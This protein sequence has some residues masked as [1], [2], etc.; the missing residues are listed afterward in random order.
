MGSYKTILFDLDGTL[1]DSGEG[2]IRCAQL[3]LRHFGLPLPSP[4]EM[5][6]FVG[7]P[8]RDSFSRFGVAPENLE[9]AMAIYRSRYNS[10]GKFE[11]FLY[12]GMMSLLKKLH[13]NGCRLLV[14]TSKPEIT[15][16]E[17]LTHLGAAPYFECIAGATMDNSRTTKAQVIAHLS[18]QVGGLSDA[19]MVGDTIFDV[20]GAAAHQIPTIG[21]A[22]GY[23]IAEDM[24]RAGAVAIAGNTTQLLDLLGVE[25]K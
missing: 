17:I 18:E 4:S 19:V 10:S 12:P 5:R 1:V 6:T 16:V 25:R 23:G 14:A 22:W 9:E 15:S 3:A 11:C 20:S 13:N 2:I 21:V 24:E 8:L 7:P